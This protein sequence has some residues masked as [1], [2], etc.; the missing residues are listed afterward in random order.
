[1]L[2]AGSAFDDVLGYINVWIA[3][4]LMWI[5][6]EMWKS[7]GL[8]VGIYV[9]LGVEETCID[10]AVVVGVFISNYVEVGD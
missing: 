5:Q 9:V 4:F 1:M 7:L 3:I 6:R 10:R 2:G 8:V